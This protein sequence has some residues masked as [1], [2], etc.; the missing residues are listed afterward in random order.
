M[1]FTDVPPE[2]MLLADWVV[3]VLPE[4]LVLGFVESWVGTLVA[5]VV[6][7]DAVLL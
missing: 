5:V 3:I 4:V 6:A 7:L 2:V 1:G